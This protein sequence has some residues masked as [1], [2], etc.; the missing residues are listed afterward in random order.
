MLELRL[1]LSTDWLSG[2]RE[3]SVSSASPEA[4]LGQEAALSVISNYWVGELKVEIITNKQTDI[5]PVYSSTTVDWGGLQLQSNTSHSFSTLS[6]THIVFWTFNILS[7]INL[8]HTAIMI[9][10]LYNKVIKSGLT[11]GDK[12]SIL[13]IHFSSSKNLPISSY[14]Y[15]LIYYYK[16]F[17]VFFLRPQQISRRATIPADTSPRIR[18]PN[19]GRRWSRESFCILSSV[20]CPSSCRKRKWLLGFSRLSLQTPPAFVFLIWRIELLPTTNVL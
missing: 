15:I 20:C 14:L 1:S 13:S 5:S 2:L 12:F 17:S 19:A 4:G 7:S 18:T 9:I 10:L 11:S 3:S 8:Q 6:N 16:I